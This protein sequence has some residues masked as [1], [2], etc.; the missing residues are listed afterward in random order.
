MNSDYFPVVKSFIGE[1]ALLPE[2][3]AAYSLSA[4]RCQLITAC[5]RDVYLVT[6]HQKRYIL[7]IYRHNQR[8]LPEIRAEWQEVMFI[9][10]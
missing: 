1:E 2:I 7:Y 5:M 4:V 8:A 6:S 10:T 3:E 9:R